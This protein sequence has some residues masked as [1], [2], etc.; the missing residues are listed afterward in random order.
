MEINEKSIDWAQ[1]NEDK[2][3][4]VDMRAEKGISQIRFAHLTGIIHV[5]DLIEDEHQMWIRKDVDT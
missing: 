3:Y 4:I 5:I 1:L 2:N